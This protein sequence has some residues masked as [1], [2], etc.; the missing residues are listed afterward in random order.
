MPTARSALYPMSSAIVKTFQDPLKSFET[1]K[2]AIRFS[3]EKPLPAALVKK[4]V[5]ARMEENA[6]RGKKSK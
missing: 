1:S 3:M 6:E 2:G 5:K 4:L